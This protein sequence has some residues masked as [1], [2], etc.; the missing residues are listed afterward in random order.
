MS[1]I[2]PRSLLRPRTA[3]LAG[4]LALAAMPALAG[5]KRAFEQTVFFGDSLTDAGYFRP[6][7]PPAAQPVTGQFTTNPGLL[8]SQFLANYYATDGSAAWLASGAEPRPAEGDNF[9]V[10]GARVGVDV[11]GAL[12]PTPSLASQLGEYLARTGG[13]A[14]PNA[15]Y[16]VWGG[17]NDLFA[18]GAGAPL[19]PTL[20]DAVGAQ[21]GM[22]A[23]L[24]GAG[25]EYIL[26]PNIPDL[27][28]TPGFLAQGPAAAAQ[29]SALARAYNDA[30]YGALAAQNLRFIPLD[31]F[32]LLREITAAPGT[33]GFTNVTGTA[34]QPQIVAQSLTC[35]PTSYV[36]PDAPYTYAF[37]DGVHPT[38]GAHAILADYAIATIEGPRQI[39]LLPQVAAGSGRARAD[40]LADQLEARGSEEGGRVWGGARID[41]LRIEQ[42]AAGEGF[43]GGGASLHVGYDRRSGALVYGGHLGIGRQTFDYAG[44]RGDF[45]QREAG[46][47]GFIGWHGERG[48]IDG[49]L[50]WTR[51]RYDVNREVPL[52]PASRRH[53]GSTD[54]D[55]LSAG[56]SGG[57]R[58]GE[59]SLRHG[60]VLR[61]LA[62]KIRI[63]G[64]VESEPELST[65][66]AFPDQD[67]DSLQ[68]SAGWQAD[69]NVDGAW[70]PWLRLTLDRELG[71]AP[72]QAFARMTSVADSA[73]YAVPAPAF[74][75]RYASLGLG[76]RGQ[77]WGMELA[78]GANLRLG[79]DDADGGS[80]WLTLGKRF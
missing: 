20:S 41:A 12:G 63:D 5:N 28:V 39:A 26:V 49:Q 54:G 2:C 36:S 66:L 77:A 3:I 79:Q 38:T 51:L 10:G 19:Q 52:G 9:A 55:N 35:N 30:L 48:W 70:Q 64:H 76:V 44:N 32:N 6:L 60:P 8:W 15:L 68:A 17:A 69:F 47:G 16:T 67:F 18:I 74:D 7:M 29:A 58:F 72:E 25:A 57:W 43:D 62:Q 37:A 14:N 75:T 33:Y 31:T 71:D 42:G 11:V 61:L 40:M 56:I 24:R 27:G 53:V 78:A 4:A 21:V 46:I 50:G 34:C 23:T 13:R 80:A 1:L 73:P 45:R 22:V 59:G 65:A